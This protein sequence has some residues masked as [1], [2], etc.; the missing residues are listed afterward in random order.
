M[1]S[2][3]RSRGALSATAARVLGLDAPSDWTASGATLGGGGSHIQGTGSLAVSNVTSATI[4]S[5]ALST[6]GA[7]EIGSIIGFDIQIPEFQPNPD[8]FGAV[9]LYIDLPSRG[10]YNVFVGQK[11]L[12]CLPR[13]SF[14]RVELLLS[15]TLQNALRATYSDLRLRFQLNTPG[16]TGPYLLD[17]I[18]FTHEESEPIDNSRN[19]DILGFEKP[20]AW[21]ASAGTTA[22]STDRTEKKKSLSVTPSVR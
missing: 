11:E 14:R 17:R 15:S 8:Y 2:T 21:L 7:N 6:L 16:G 10:I 19:I 20:A 4:T 9:Q 1:E 5:R 3:A 12:T 18:S 22:P 13:S